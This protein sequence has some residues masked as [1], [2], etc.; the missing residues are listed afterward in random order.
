MKNIYLTF[1]TITLTLSA[2][3]STTGCMLLPVITSP[4]AAPISMPTKKEKALAAGKQWLPQNI[5]H[6]AKLE[7]S[8]AYK[9]V[10]KGGINAELI[11]LGVEKVKLPQRESK[12]YW[13]PVDV[14]AGREIALNVQFSADGYTSN[15]EFTVP[16]LTEGKTYLLTFDEPFLKNG[17]MLVSNRRRWSNRGFGGGFALVFSWGL[18]TAQSKTIKINAPKDTVSLLL[19]ERTDKGK[20][21]KKISTKLI[22]QYSFR[23]KKGFTV[24]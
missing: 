21:K 20:S 2:S 10:I 1:I 17:E 19:Y 3:L 16:P 8:G 14:P 4:S 5:G 23:D 7:L 11:L 6:T 18:L 12:K 22:Y 15:V 9:N 24:P 13:S